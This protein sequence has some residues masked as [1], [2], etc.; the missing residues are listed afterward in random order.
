VRWFFLDIG[1]RLPGSSGFCL[2]SYSHVYLF[3][4][5][6]FLS[7]LCETIIQNLLNVVNHAIQHLLDG[8]FDLSPQGKAA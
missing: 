8:D 2:P 6:P 3:G 5:H 4:F 1:Y 7:C